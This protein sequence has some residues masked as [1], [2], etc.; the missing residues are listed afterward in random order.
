MET[1][2]DVS[3]ELVHSND[4]NGDDSSDAR[5]FSALGLG[6]SYSTLS[7]VRED[8]NNIFAAATRHG[9]K[10]TSLLTKADDDC[11]HMRRQRRGICVIVNQKEFEPHTQLNERRG[12][13]VDAENLK[14]T[15]QAL[16]FE[17]H[18]QKNLTEKQLSRE[19][20]HWSQYDH[21]D[22]DAFVFC[23]LS[24]G[25]RDLIYHTS[26]KISTDQIFEPFTG[27]NCRSLLGKPKLFFIQA[28]RGDNL[29]KGALARDQ[30]DSVNGDVYRLPSHADFLIAYSTVAGFYSWRNTING[31]WFIQS[32]CAVLQDPDLVRRNDIL[33]LMTL[34][35]KHVAFKFESSVP[36]NSEMDKRKQI[37]CV[38][39]TLTRKLF[40][41]PKITGSLV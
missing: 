20:K 4:K 39:Y 22:C 12:T 15:F 32:L 2:T 5:G 35:N 8:V 29:D 38:T 36:G 34:V 40:L 18:M 24:H 23:L 7:K 1:L 13:D 17:V 9:E 30:P 3:E 19:L 14:K 28:C 26:G 21:A 11:Y 25:E 33:S 10:I 6:S 41:A 37:P 16:S 27:E 31:S